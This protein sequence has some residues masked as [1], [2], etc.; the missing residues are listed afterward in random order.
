MPAP[1]AVR[2]AGARVLPHPERHGWARCPGPQFGLNPPVRLVDQPLGGRDRRAPE[3]DAFTLQKQIQPAS[4]PCQWQRIGVIQAGCFGAASSHR[5]PCPPEL[6]LGGLH[7]HPYGH[8]RDRDAAGTS[9]RP[10]GDFRRS[11]RHRGAAVAAPHSPAHIT[12]PATAGR[13]P[14]RA[15]RRAGVPARRRASPR[16]S[17]CCSG[18]NAT[19]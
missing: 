3:R 9:L 10:C 16:R 11:Q 6:S 13:R 18:T 2:I 7:Q 8:R 19:A 17:S 4:D 12:A 1:G 14:P 5:R 15:S